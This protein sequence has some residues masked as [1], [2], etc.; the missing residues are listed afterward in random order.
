MRLGQAQQ[1]SGQ[2]QAAQT[3]LERALSLREANDDKN[4]PWLAEAQVAL[5]ECLVSLGERTRARTL[6]A[7]AKAIHATHRELGEYFKRPL[8]E[9]VERLNR[10]NS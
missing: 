1:R 5:A 2:Q 4:S 7:S 10:R 6:L 3:N 8:R 9:L